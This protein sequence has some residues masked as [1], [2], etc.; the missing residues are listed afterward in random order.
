MKTENK[1]GLAAGQIWH[2]GIASIEILQLGK[3]LIH[4]RITKQLGHRRV[5][6][7]LSAVEAMQEYLRDT[8]AR[9]IGSSPG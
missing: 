4:Y 9:L 6:A 1:W 3:R 7:Q 5:S 8:G 2:T